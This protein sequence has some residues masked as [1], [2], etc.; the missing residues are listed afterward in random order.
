[1]G[2]ETVDPDVLPR[3]NKRMTLNQFSQAADFLRAN[4]IDLR[5]FILVQPP[6]M[7]ETESLY[8]AERSLDFAFDCGAS[9]ATL[10]PTRAGNGAMEELA[11]LGQFSPPRIETL[12]AALVYGL[13]LK[14]GRVFVDLW[15][16]EQL[17]GCTRCRARRSS[18]LRE[19]NLRQTIVEPVDCARCGNKD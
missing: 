14:R 12:E 4:D 16:L 6:F 9:V 3:L 1:M 5:V 7:E 13:A 15:D 10:I 17:R 11:K 8:W 19:M 18:R 2:L